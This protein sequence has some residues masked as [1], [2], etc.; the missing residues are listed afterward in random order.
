M[1]DLGRILVRH[2][3]PRLAAGELTHLQRW[4]VDPDL[5]LAQWQGY[6]AASRRGQLDCGQPLRHRRTDG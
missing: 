3:S 5:A 4:P 6:V 1:D 2:P